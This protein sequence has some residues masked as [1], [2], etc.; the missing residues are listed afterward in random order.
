M[1]LA[2]CAAVASRQYYFVASGTLNMFVHRT[3]HMHAVLDLFWF[4]C[5]ACP[6]VRAQHKV[7]LGLHAGPKHTSIDKDERV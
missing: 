7:L 1:P 4:E 3:A 6:H 5:T 2:T